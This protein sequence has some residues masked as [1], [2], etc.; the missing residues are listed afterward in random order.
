MKNLKIIPKGKMD[1]YSMFIATRFFESIQ[2]Y[3]NLELSHPKWKGNLLRFYYNPIRLT[4]EFERNL[5]SN[6]QTLHI[7][8]DKDSLFENDKNI[9][10]IV[11]WTIKTYS[12]Y[13]KIKDNKTI[14]YKRI[15]FTNHERIK[16]KT[17]SIPKDI[18]ELSYCCFEKVNE[19]KEIKLD[20]KIKIIGN[21]C[22][23]YCSNL[24][25]VTL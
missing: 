19:L 23:E 16:R 4:N 15:V 25:S 20:N 12:E 10:F 5:F 11:F 14:E 17:I 22:F 7:Y 24:T 13:L 8:D 1:Y 2:D 6:I 3:I 9:K 18:N 21:N